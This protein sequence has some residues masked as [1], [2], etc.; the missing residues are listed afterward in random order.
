[1]SDQITEAEVV[2][3]P[4]PSRELVPAPSATITT[5]VKAS[6]LVERLAT[7]REAMTDAMERDVDYGVIPGTTKPTLLKPGAEKLAVLFQ[8]DAQ[9]THDE[10]WG[11]GDHLTVPAKTIVYHVPTGARLGSGEGMCST[12]E[13]KYAYRRQELTCPECGKANIRRS[14][15]RNEQDA[16]PGWY[17]WA[18]TD[19]CGANFKADDAR[20][21]SQAPGDIDNPDLPDLWNTV[22]KMARKRAL[23]DAVLLVTG[24]SALFTQDMEDVAASADT[25]APA[26]GAAPAAAQ[27]NGAARVTAQPTK[28]TERVATAKQRG[29]INGKASEKGLSPTALAVIV[30]AAAGWDEPTFE[31]DA[32]A[33]AWLRKGMDRLPGRL[34][35]PILEGIAQVEA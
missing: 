23:I 30:H 24:A 2:D 9:T 32:A 26:G 8:L 34:V 1:M 4:E 11:P 28:G 17:C 19:G 25:A 10:R 5:P 31:S 22:I 20:I 16:N 6:D 21:T 14:K 13:R 7:I 27:D 18:K 15:P 29:L 35:D 3:A 33:E 12:R